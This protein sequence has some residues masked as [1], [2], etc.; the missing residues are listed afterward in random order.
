MSKLREKPLLFPVP[1]QLGRN[2]VL[3]GNHGRVFDLGYWSSH[4]IRISGDLSS[5]LTR[6]RLSL[7]IR[8]LP[9]GIIVL[10]Y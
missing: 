5:P 1:Q 6:N 3:P 10:S 4:W 2:G 7:C 9:N 8:L